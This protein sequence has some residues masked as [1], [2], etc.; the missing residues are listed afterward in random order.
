V[1]GARDHDE[2]RIRDGVLE[3]ACEDERRA[4]VQIPPDQQGRHS[5][6]RQQIAL[7]GLGHHKQ[8]SPHALRANVCG[9]RFEERHELGRRIAGEQP[10]KRGGEQ[11]VRRG[12]HLPHALD[13][14]P[15]LLLGQR[16]FQPA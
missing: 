8:R 10:R 1:T 14:D 11:V 6:A 16:P 5:D 13:P 3:P 7:V 9:H 15:H 4:R 2:L 12:E